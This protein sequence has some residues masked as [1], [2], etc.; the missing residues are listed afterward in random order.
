MKSKISVRQR[1]YSALRILNLALLTIIAMFVLSDNSFAQGRLPFIGTRTF[2]S[3]DNLGA[4][5]IV[6]IRNDGFTT[7]KTNMWPEDRDRSVTFSGVLNAKRILKWT[8]KYYLKIESGTHIVLYDGPYPADRG[9][10][11][12][13]VFPQVPEESSDVQRILTTLPSAES[14]QMPHKQMVPDILVANLYRQGGQVFQT[15]NRAWLDRYFEKKLADLLWKEMETE[16]GLDCDI[17]LGCAQDAQ[18]RKFVIARPTFEV[19]KAQ[20]QVSYEN[21]GV[22]GSTVFLLVGGEAEW[23]ISDIKYGDGDTLVGTLGEVRP[24]ESN[25]VQRTPATPATTASTQAIRKDDSA[26]ASLLNIYPAPANVQIQPTQPIRKAPGHPTVSASK[27]TYAEVTFKEAKDLEGLAKTFPFLK[28]ALE[29]TITINKD[30][31]QSF[32]HTTVL[33]SELYQAGQVRLLLVIFSGN[34]DCGTAGCA[35]FAYIDQGNGFEE[36]L[37]G[38]GSVLIDSRDFVYISNDL[39]RVLLGCGSK[40]EINPWRRKNNGFEFEGLYKGPQKLKPCIK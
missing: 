38:G 19:R 37:W 1:L 5:A 26:G 33:V 39:Q 32:F 12:S 29:E 23:K 10:P 9:M 40:G 35:L 31:D 24:E 28:E 30:P 18:V 3:S 14:S 25:N 20:V 36:A 11:C 7:V 8:S 4:M 27:Q 6:S 13:E 16:E 15:E 17:L 22:G 34:L 21:F 2:C